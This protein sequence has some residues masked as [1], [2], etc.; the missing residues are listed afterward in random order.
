MVSAGV[1]SAVRIGAR[2]EGELGCKGTR[3]DHKAKVAEDGLEA[4]RARQGG[5][6]ATRGASCHDGGR[7]VVEQCSF[8]R[9][10]AREH[11]LQYHHR[12]SHTRYHQ[13][14]IGFMSF[15]KNDRSKIKKMFGPCSQKV[16]LHTSRTRFPDP[17][18][19]CHWQVV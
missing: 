13:V 5:R 8:P 10:A 4:G 16:S 18:T 19:G 12:K 2:R 6:R 14:S 9:A 3:F 17:L 1:S 11:F 15:P 7:H